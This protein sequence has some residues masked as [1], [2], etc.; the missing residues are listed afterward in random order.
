MKKQIEDEKVKRKV[1]YPQEKF[2]SLHQYDFLI[3]ARKLYRKD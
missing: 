3:N 1:Y 2:L